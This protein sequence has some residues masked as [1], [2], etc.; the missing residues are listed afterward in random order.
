MCV[1]GGMGLETR[2]PTHSASF[3]KRVS[4]LSP[5]K[6]KVGRFLR[7]MRSRR[8]KRYSGVVF[9]TSGVQTTSEVQGAVGIPN[10]HAP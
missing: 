8:D 10:T 3:L 1:T 6:A 5:V 2:G 4:R 9:S 7:R